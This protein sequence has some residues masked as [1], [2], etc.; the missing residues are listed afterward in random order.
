MSPWA[1]VWSC[2][3]DP[4]F[5]CFDTIQACDGRTDRQTYDHTTTAY[6]ALV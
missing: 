1:V 5:S 6:T 2:L 4:M 3:R